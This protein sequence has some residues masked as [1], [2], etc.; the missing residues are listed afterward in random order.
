MAIAWGCFQVFKEMEV[1][2]DNISLTKSLDQSATG[3]EEVGVEL[4]LLVMSGVGFC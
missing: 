2:K 1:G 4:V 3:Q